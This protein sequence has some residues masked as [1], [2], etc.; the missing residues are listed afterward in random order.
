[1]NSMR[2]L[3]PVKPAVVRVHGEGSSTEHQAER[4]NCPVM[5]V[6][7]PAIGGGKTA[8]N[9]RSLTAVTVVQVSPAL[10]G[11]AGAWPVSPSERRIAAR[12]VQ[13]ANRRLL[14]RPGIA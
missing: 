10:L 9:P 2:A 14:Q 5:T 13:F 6:H 8:S 3:C 11:I 4:V 7:R 12:L 1:V